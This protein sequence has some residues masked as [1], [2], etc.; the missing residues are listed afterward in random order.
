MALRDQ[1]YLPLYVQDYLTD[2]KLNNCCASS[3][4]IYIKIMCIMHKSDEY[5]CILL[6]Q[7]YEQTDSK[8]K[9]FAI[10]ISKQIPFT[11]DEIFLALTELINEKVIYVLEDKI[12]Q[13]RMI[14]DNDVS[15]KRADAGKKSQFARTKDAA[16]EEQTHEQ[17]TEYENE[18]ENVL[19]IYNRYPS[20]CPIKERSTGKCLRDKNKIKA[21]LS[22]KSFDDII[23]TID[24]Y[25][26]DCKKTKTYIK[27]FGTFLNNFPEQTAIPID[28]KKKVVFEKLE[29]NPEWD[30]S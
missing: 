28:N 8:I 5:G 2:E 29:M 30:R 24:N 3:Q 6:E 16:K 26:E 21:L 22:K 25:I 10:K 15:L 14:K 19:L 17:N 12:C 23:Q 1:P 27:N 18:Y 9:N 13:K 4:G 20:K 11:T 7:K